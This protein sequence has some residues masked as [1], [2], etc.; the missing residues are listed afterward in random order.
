MKPEEIRYSLF[1]SA[2]DDEWVCVSDAFPSLS[3][4]SD[5]PLEA[6]DGYLRM[7]RDE[8]PNLWRR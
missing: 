3:W 1:W 6:L 2:E 8:F 5:T 7:L 4:L